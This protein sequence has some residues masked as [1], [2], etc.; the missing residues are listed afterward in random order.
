MQ[1]LQAIER[2]AQAIQ[3]SVDSFIEALLREVASASLSSAVDSV[4]DTSS[5]DLRPVFAKIGLAADEGDFASA[6]PGQG[7]DDVE[8]LLG[9]ELIVAALA[10]A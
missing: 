3:A 4:V 1:R 2:N 8:A 10:S 5:N 6:E 7:I 9:G